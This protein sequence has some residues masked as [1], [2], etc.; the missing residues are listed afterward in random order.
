ML[1]CDLRVGILIL[2][3]ELK[4]ILLFL[5]I[6]VLR[7][8]LVTLFGRNINVHFRSNWANDL[9]CLAFDIYIRLGDIIDILNIL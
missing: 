4:A 1:E 9:Q 3:A 2:Q 6:V 5:H 7:F 8:L